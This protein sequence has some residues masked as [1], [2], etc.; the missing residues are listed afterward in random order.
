M[1]RCMGVDYL[2][3]PSQ[4]IVATDFK[5]LC[6]I[7]KNCIKR[8]NLDRTVVGDSDVVLAIFLGCEP[9]MASSLSRHDV[10]KLTQGFGELIGIQVAGQF[11]EAMTSSRTMW[12][13][14]NRGRS[15]SS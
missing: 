15:A 8:T 4:Q 2:Q 12:R 13:R 3:N 7:S 5:M 6:D 11:H 9:H 14:I 10:P 1:K